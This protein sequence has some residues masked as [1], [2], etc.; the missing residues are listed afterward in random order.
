M[1]SRRCAHA[2]PRLRQG[3]KGGG[4]GRSRPCEGAAPSSGCHSNGR[5][6]SRSGV[7]F[8]TMGASSFEDETLK[9]RQLKLENQRTL[10]EKKQRKKR[11]EHLMVQP[12]PEAKLC[13]L[14]SKVGEEQTPL[15]ACSPSVPRVGIDDPVASL[16][17]V[18]QDQISVGSSITEN[19][20]DQEKR[21]EIQS[22][23]VSKMDL[24]DLLQKR[25]ENY[26]I[27]SILGCTF[28]CIYTSLSSTCV[29]PYN[30]QKSQPDYQLLG[31]L[32]VG[33]SKHLENYCCS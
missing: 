22:D 17:Q 21:K 18:A 28:S 15:V 30:S 26:C 8:A 25:G 31:F 14:K 19:Y 3:W 23:V 2:Q 29:L 33:R 6:A 1:R 27:S 7:T 11:L 13:K 16:N 5:M 12:N 10:L 24:Q 9:L 32:G 20:T 4:G